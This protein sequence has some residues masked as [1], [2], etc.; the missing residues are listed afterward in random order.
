MD[1]P[2]TSV[3]FPLLA[4]AQVIN[5]DPEHNAVYIR[6]ASGQFIIS[7][8][9]MLYRGNADQY[10]V[11]QQPLPLIGT[12]GL[13]A[14]PSNDDRLPIWLGA[15]YP[16]I[17]DAITSSSII[18][19]SQ[20]VYDSHWS[21]YYS[22]MDGF[23]QYYERYP[24]GTNII[25]NSSNTEPSTFRHIVQLGETNQYG[26]PQVRTQLPDSERVPNP[27]SPYYV[28][29]NHPSGASA[30]ITPSGVVT[31]TAGNP[32]LSTINMTPNGIITVTAG[33]PVSGSQ[34]TPEIILNAQ[35]GEVSIYSQNQ[36]GLITMDGSG[37]ITIKSAS[38]EI[39]VQAANTVNIT[40]A[41]AVIITS[42]GSDIDLTT[43]SH[44]DSVNTIINTFNSHVHS[45]VTSG[46]GDSGP[47][48]VPLP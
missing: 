28:S 25:I 16:T 48:T 10:R 3:N 1:G 34:A 9:R 29:I 19:D 35:T 24:D 27:P 18:Q 2:K 23:G 8:A 46:S 14:F 21:G 42:T 17:E 32:Q 41:E 4:V 40:A 11:Q 20:I 7:P 26:T 43:N 47:P 36:N 31:I 6:L 33:N 12:W 15:Y 22:L 5:Y 39:I 37:N 38:N 45:G 13:V 30:T 44:I